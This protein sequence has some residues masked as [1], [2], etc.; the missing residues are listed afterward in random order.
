MRLT[1]SAS[2]LPLTAALLLAT[3]LTGCS[4]FNRLSQV[5]EEPKLSKIQNPAATQASVT[6]PMPTPTPVERQPNSLWRPGARAFFKDQRATQIGDIMTVTIN[7]AD[8][9][10]LSNSTTRTRNNSESADAPNLLGYE[11]KI[12]ERLPGNNNAT[13]DPTSLISLGS[14]SNSTGTGQI[15]RTDTIALRIAAVVTQVLPNGNLVVNG[16]QEVRVNFETRV[17]QIAGVIRPQDIRSDN[18]IPYDRI[19]EARIA[20]G[21]RGQITDMQQPRWGQQVY[22]ILFPF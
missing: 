11:R 21:G 20:Y 7:I 15:T 4:T 14:Q 12:W 19:A 8:T 10:S 2:A 17:L 3:S 6:M 5:G 22:D 1:L 13:L 9:A 18:E 16:S